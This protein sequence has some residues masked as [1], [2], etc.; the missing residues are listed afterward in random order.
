MCSLIAHVVLCVLVLV[1]VRRVTV[2]IVHIGHED[3]VV[4][5]HFCVAIFVRDLLYQEMFSLH[6]WEDSVCALYDM[7]DMILVSG[8]WCEYRDCGTG[9][10]TDDV[11]HRIRLRSSLTRCRVRDGSLPIFI[12][13]SV[14]LQT[15]PHQ[16]CS[17]FRL[18]VA[19][20]QVSR[21]ADQLG[22]FCTLHFRVFICMW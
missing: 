8:L 22:C 16:R 15:L 6:A 1:G 12:C 5:I 13:D 20:I 19:A 9:A 4:V 14:Y 3:V 18:D 21:F 17:L 7:T 10:T 2:V 11:L